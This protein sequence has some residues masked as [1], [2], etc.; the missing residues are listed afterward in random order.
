ME[1]GARARSAASRRAQDSTAG[2]TG[3]FDTTALNAVGAQIKGVVLQL[4]EFKWASLVDGEAPVSIVGPR[5]EVGVQRGYATPISDRSM[6]LI[7]VAPPGAPSKSLATLALTRHSRPSHT[8]RS[9]LTAHRSPLA[10]H[11]SPLTAHHSPLTTR[12]SPLTTRRSSPRTSTPSAQPVEETSVILPIDE[13]GYNESNALMIVLTRYTASPVGTPPKRA[14]IPRPKVGTSTLS[15]QVRY[16]GQGIQSRL[17][18]GELDNQVRLMIAIRLGPPCSPAAAA[19]APRDVHS[20]AA[21][22]L[23]HTSPT[24]LP[25]RHS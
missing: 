19:N 17:T 6:A 10:A 18:S 9:P 12:H 13:Y 24:S 16:Q 2:A 1:L 4:A 20:P 8:H 15:L 3:G 21:A 5:L 25:T 7:Q 14:G 11:R 23:S 22:T